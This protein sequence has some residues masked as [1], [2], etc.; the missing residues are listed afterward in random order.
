MVMIGWGLSYIPDSLFIAPASIVAVILLAVPA[1]VGLVINKGFKGILV[2]IVLG[3]FSLLIETI[4]IHTGFPYSEF[5][6]TQPF[7]F[8]LFGTTPWTVA[9]AWSPLVIGAYVLASNYGPFWKQFGT[10]ISLLV[11]L[12]LVLDPGSVARGMWEYTNGGAFYG[13]PLV[14]FLGWVFSGTIAFLL[15]HL[16]VGNKK[17]V[18]VPTLTSSSYILSVTLWTGVCLG[19]QLY[20]PATIGGAL[21]LISLAMLTKQHHKE[22]YH[23]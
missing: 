7:G 21:L 16:L 23:S 9:L 5:H 17:L 13:V 12:D 4:G 2:I 18:S 19:Y 20:I 6:Y 8:L 1:F 10:Y 11:S 14:N 15:I 3:L 22:Q